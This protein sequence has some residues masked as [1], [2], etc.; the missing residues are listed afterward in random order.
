MNFS[1]SSH[2]RTRLS[3]L[4]ILLMVGGF[5]L[6]MGCIVWKLTTRV[7]VAAVASPTPEP[8]P[9][10]LPT[11]GPLL[12]GDATFRPTPEQRAVGE[13]FTNSGAAEAEFL[14]CCQDG[15][16]FWIVRYPSGDVW[17]FLIGGDGSVQ[18]K[19][20]ILGPPQVQPTSL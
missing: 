6:T 10:P 17:G 20:L 3:W 15:S 18:K 16:V 11:P 12:N 4:V 19:F 13:R 2:A 1:I 7:T 5:W 8:T 9:D 14:A